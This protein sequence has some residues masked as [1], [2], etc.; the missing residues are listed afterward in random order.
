[1]GDL[2]CMMYDLLILSP[3]R[4]YELSMLAEI[5]FIIASLLPAIG[6]PC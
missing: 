2:S 3:Q 4:R 6:S 5:C 1:M